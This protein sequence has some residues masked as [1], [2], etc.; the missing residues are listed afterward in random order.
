MAFDGHGTTVKFGTSSYTFK[1]ISVG[2]VGKEGEDIETTLLAT[3]GGKTFMPADLYDPGDTT[4]TVEHDPTINVT[5]PGPV[6][7]IEYDFGGQGLP[8][9]VDGY[10]KSYKVSGAETGQRVTATL[11]IKHTGELDQNTTTSGA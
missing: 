2:E 7:S 5:V 1:I 4:L 3:T 8:I 10:I 6:E 9:E 11:T